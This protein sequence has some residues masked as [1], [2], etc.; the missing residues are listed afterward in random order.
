MLENNFVKGMQAD[1]L[2][3]AGIKFIENA[4]T[5]R[6]LLMRNPDTQALLIMDLAGKITGTTRN[7]G[8]MIGIDPEPAKT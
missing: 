6:A 1:T 5:R 2:V 4:E 8:T 3:H 7:N